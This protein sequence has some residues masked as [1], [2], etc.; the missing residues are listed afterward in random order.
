MG[1]SQAE[2]MQRTHSNGRLERVKSQEQSLEGCFQTHSGGECFIGPGAA[3]RPIPISRPDG[4]PLWLWRRMDPEG[5]GAA[6][7][8]GEEARRLAVHEECRLS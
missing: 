2:R 5:M 3:I 4:P 7:G 6:R 1:P 8:A